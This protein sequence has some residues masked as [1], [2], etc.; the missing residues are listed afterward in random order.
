MI[1]ST[2][3]AR[4]SSSA[5]SG[6][7]ST[8]FKLSPMNPIACRRISGFG[9]TA[10]PANFAAGEIAPRQGDEPVTVIGLSTNSLRQSPDSRG[11]PSGAPDVETVPMDADARAIVEGLKGLSPEAREAVLRTIAEGSK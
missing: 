6:T 1:S 5:F 4:A 10:G 7:F 9:L 3:T 2:E 8:P 11:A